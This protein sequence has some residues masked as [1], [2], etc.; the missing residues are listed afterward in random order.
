MSAR[1][2]SLVSVALSCVWTK[3]FVA[4]PEPSTVKPIS[5]CPGVSRGFADLR[6]LNVGPLGELG[7]RR[8]KLRL[9]KALRRAAGAEHGEADIGLPRREPRFRGPSSPECRPVG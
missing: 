9:D 6:L 1:W 2:V 5:A 3:L 4:Q 7:L 8:A